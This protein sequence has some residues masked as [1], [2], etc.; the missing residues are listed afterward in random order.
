[1]KKKYQKQI[2]ELGL[3]RCLNCGHFA[4]GYIDIYKIERTFLTIPIHT[5]ESGYLLRCEHCHHEKV[6]SKEEMISMVKTAKNRLPINLQHNLW[7][8]IY[9]THKRLAKREDES[10]NLNTFFNKVKSE[11]LIDLPYEVDQSELNY[12]FNAYLTNLT[13]ASKE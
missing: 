7:K 8:R 4:P 13:I 11:V 9:K 2:E 6:I 12:I 3:I 1:M 5:I 10:T